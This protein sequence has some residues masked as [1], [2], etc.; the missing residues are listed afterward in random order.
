MNAWRNATIPHSKI[1]HAHQLI[2][3]KTAS[4]T[5]ENQFNIRQCKDLRVPGPYLSTGPVLPLAA[6]H[7]PCSHPLSLLFGHTFA[8][9]TSITN[10]SSLLSVHI[11][12]QVRRTL[13]VSAHLLTG[14]QFCSA[15]ALSHLTVAGVVHTRSFAALSTFSSCWVSFED[16]PVV[17]LKSADEPSAAS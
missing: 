17:T 11:T 12:V 13:F 14:T 7:N 16:S 8:K 2:S 1:W 4:N 5:A 10:F 15:C 6:L 3:R 9:I